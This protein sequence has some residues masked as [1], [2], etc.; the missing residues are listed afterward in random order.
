MP[1]VKKKSVGGNP[2]LFASLAKKAKKAV[3]LGKKAKELY[4]SINTLYEE[5][6]DLYDALIEKISTSDIKGIGVLLETEL[7]KIDNDPSNELK[8][9]IEKVKKIYDSIPIE[10]L[11]KIQATIKGLLESTNLIQAP[12]N[13]EGFLNQGA[14]QGANPIQVPGNLEGFLNQGAK[15]LEGF[16]NQ[17]ANQ[18]ANQANQANQKSK[19]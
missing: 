9:K 11:S 1:K 18:D 19:F 6:K 3:E 8:L 12:G 15:N 2:I 17:G 4:D 16:L 7:N 10:K 14:N 13:K 5:K